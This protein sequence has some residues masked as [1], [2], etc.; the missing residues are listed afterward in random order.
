[1][2]KFEKYGLNADD[3]MKKMKVEAIPRLFSGVK[4][5]GYHQVADKLKIR[6]EEVELY[7]IEAIK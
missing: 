1:M 7:I 6:K 5:V 2:K 4:N 3:L